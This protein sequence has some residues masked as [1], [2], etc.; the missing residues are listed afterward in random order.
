VKILKQ[1]I[2][3]A[4]I[5]LTLLGGTASAFAA[6]TSQNPNQGDFVTLKQLHQQEV[7]LNTQIK[8]E[9]QAIKT[10]LGKENAAN[11]ATRKQIK[12]EM[13]TVKPIRQQLKTLKAQLKKAN[14]NKGDKATIA[15][16]KQQINSTKSQIQAKMEPIK[17][18]NSA[19]KKENEANKQLNTQLSPVRKEIKATNSELKNLGTPRKALNNKLKTDRQA[20][21]MTAIK[22]DLDKTISLEQSF[23]KLKQKLL[24]EEQQI[25]SMV[26]K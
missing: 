10:D 3:S 23:L 25:T 13:A 9:K 26:N 24:Q 8:N 7:N 5:G 2:V 6:T 20:K 1:A 18:Q 14:Q 16:L 17:T 19:L 11:K 21:N 15:N 4:A 22:A 12:T